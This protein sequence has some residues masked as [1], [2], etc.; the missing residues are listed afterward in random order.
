MTTPVPPEAHGI[1]VMLEDRIKPSLLKPRPEGDPR[2]RHHHGFK[3]HHHGLTRHL[4]HHLA[5]PNPQE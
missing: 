4:A 2:E 1:P 5:L 3:D